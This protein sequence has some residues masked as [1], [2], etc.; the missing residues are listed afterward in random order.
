ML[1]STE[2]IRELVA[3]P[4]PPGGEQAIRA[5]VEAHVAELGYET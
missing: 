5:A 3:I 4:G 2:L 1:D